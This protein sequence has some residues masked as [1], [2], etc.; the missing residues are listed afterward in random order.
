MRCYS[1]KEIANLVSVNE[2]TVRRWIRDGELKSTIL[3]KKSGNT[4]KESDLHK[5][6]N[7]KPKYRVLIEV[8]EP[9]IDELYNGK[10]YELLDELISERN[11]LDN[12]I[13]RIEKLLEE[14]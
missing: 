7:R 1:V 3:S 13:N 2:E 4:I 6:L 8:K 10:L 11:K 9:K 5:F 12:Y 14:S